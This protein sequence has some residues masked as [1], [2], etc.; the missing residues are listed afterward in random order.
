ML[1]NQLGG[2]LRPRFNDLRELAWNKYV[3]FKQK[4]LENASTSSESVCLHLK[5]I[6]SKNKPTVQEVFG[7]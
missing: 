5:L 1:Y 6:T 3:V 4:E 2:A 7:S